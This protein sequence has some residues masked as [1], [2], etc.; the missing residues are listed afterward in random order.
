VD[1][2]EPIEHLVST[3]EN[4]SFHIIAGAFSSESNANRLGD[5]LRNEG[6]T[7]TIGEG[8]GMTLVSIQSFQTRA[9][10]KAGLIELKTVVPNAW[11]HKW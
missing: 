11:I 5:K 7:I 8:R 1:Q 10:A 3:E 9:E 4:F 6:Y 2:S